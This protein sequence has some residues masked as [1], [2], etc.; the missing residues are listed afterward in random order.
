MKKL[1][2]ALLCLG[3]AAHA[4]LIFDNGG[5]STLNPGASNLSDTQQAQDFLLTSI[6]SLTSVRFWS[7]EVSSGDFL[8]S[9]LWEIRTNRLGVPG[10]TVVA[11]G[12]AA[13]T[14][15]AAGTTLGLNQFQND[16][17]ISV[18]N[19][20]AG[21]YWLTIHNGPL[22]SNAFTD[23]YWSWADPNATAFAGQE[24]AL[25][26]AGTAWTTNDSEAAFQIFGTSSS[27]PEPGS[28]ILAGVAL[29]TIGLIRKRD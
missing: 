17:N 13:P 8:G 28:L 4:S 23:F 26:P 5:P 27:T 16:F 11:S 7:L 3:G 2:V 10:S 19:L 15:T 1:I 6:T 20:A 14:R 9:V 21:T 24:F 12:T 22:S 18:N 29:L 25:N